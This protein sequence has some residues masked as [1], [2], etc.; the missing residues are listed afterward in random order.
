MKN[1]D[2][3]ENSKGFGFKNQ[4]WEIRFFFKIPKFLG[5]KSNLKAGVIWKYK[6]PWGKSHKFE[7]RKLGTQITSDLGIGQSNSTRR[8]WSTLILL[9]D[10]LQLYILTLYY[11]LLQPY[12]LLKP[13][14][15]VNHQ[16]IHKLAIDLLSSVETA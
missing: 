8:I 7:N 11:I 9:Q 15:W 1:W 4:L 5:W 13:R 6:N 16:D 12:A 2:H 14:K 3:I 10:L